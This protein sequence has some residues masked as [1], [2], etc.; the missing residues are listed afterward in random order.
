ML[1][2]VPGCVGFK[3]RALCLLLKDDGCFSLLSYLSCSQWLQIR[4]PWIKLSVK[5][6]CRL[7][8]FCLSISSLAGRDWHAGGICLY[9]SSPFS[10]SFSFLRCCWLNRS[11]AWLVHSAGGKAWS[12]SGV[13]KSF[14]YYLANLANSNWKPCSDHTFS[15]FSCTVWQ[16]WPLVPWW[17]QLT[18]L[19][20]PWLPLS[21]TLKSSQKLSGSP[22]LSIRGGLKPLSARNNG[23]A[24]NFF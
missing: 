13:F 21:N 20:F 5:C 8:P 9:V 18:L 23:G 16:I 6:F 4:P 10:G 15:G 24:I 3:G 11:H 1:T 19:F 2:S 14:S 7:F 22:C 17:S 12:T